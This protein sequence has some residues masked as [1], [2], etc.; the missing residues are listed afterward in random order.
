MLLSN[1]KNYLFVHI[2][3]TGGSSVRAVLSRSRWQEPYYIPQMIC[4]RISH[5]TG[6]KLGVKLP[7]HAP[8]IA[9]QEMLKAPHFDSLFKFAFVRNPWDRL[10]SAY[11]HFTRE[12]KKIL[13]ANDI[14]SLPDFAAWI[15]SDEIGYDGEAGEFIRAI[16]RPQLDYIVNLNQEIIVDFIGRYERLSNDFELLCEKLEIDGAQLPHKRNSKRA[17]TF[18]EQYDS[19][20]RDLVGEFYRRDIET[21]AY[22][23]DQNETHQSAKSEDNLVGNSTKLSGPP[24]MARAG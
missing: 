13:K 6:H 7:R 15:L 10:V 20:S 17:S 5:M 22:S 3:K 1:R 4:H 19:A 23:F 8:V 18:Q 2:A 21:F 16:R 14:R 11:C 12:Q 9:A 24:D